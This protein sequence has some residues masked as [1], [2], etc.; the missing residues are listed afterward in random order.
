MYPTLLDEDV[1]NTL[2]NETQFFVV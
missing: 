2:K 1:Y